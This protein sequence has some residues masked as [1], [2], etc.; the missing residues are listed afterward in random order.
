MKAII[1]IVLMLSVC[2]LSAQTSVFDARIHQDR[3]EAKVTVEKGNT[4]YS[5]SKYLGTTVQSI[6]GRNNKQNANLDIGEQLYVSVSPDKIVTSFQAAANPRAIN[7]KTSKGDNLYRI[8]KIT[9]VSADDIL[10]I[11]GRT[12]QNLSV[13]DVLLIGW[14]DWPTTSTYSAQVVDTPPTSTIAMIDPEVPSTSTPP[15]KKEAVKITPLPS[16]AFGV[17]H[18]YTIPTL[19]LYD[20]DELMRQIEESKKEEIKTAKGI[21]YWEKSNYQQTE[22]IVMHPTAKVNSKISL[23]NPMLKRKVEATVVGELLEDSYAHDVSIVISPSVAD[24]LGA[25]DR[26][27]LVEMTYVE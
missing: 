22:L 15:V 23:Y 27:F 1:S 9:G 21:A 10:R 3:L 17:M 24:A 19:A 5:I 26:R 25:L 14:I 13:G 8:S 6:L 18:P 11:N 2:S 4:V 16:I 7:I 12:N 20:I